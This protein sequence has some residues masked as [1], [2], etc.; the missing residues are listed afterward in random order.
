MKQKQEE[1]TLDGCDAI[2][3]PSAPD[4]RL[5]P[6]PLNEEWLASYQEAVL[7]AERPIIDAHHHLWAHRGRYLFDEILNDVRSGHNVKAT[8][9]VEADTMYRID[10]DPELACI[11]E[12]EFI[13][14]VAAMSA[15]GLCGDVRVCAGIVGFTNMLQ[16][17]GAG[18]IMDAHLARGGARFKGIRHCSAFDPDPALNTT[19]IVVPPGLLGATEFLNGFRHLSRRQLS[20][21]AWV[22]FTQLHELV[23]LADAFPDTLIV[24]DH[25]GA[26]IGIGQYEAD[27]V[28]VFE[29]WKAS[30]HTLALRENVFVKLGGFGM[31][32]F[33]FGLDQATRPASSA[34]LAGKWAPYVET[35][36]EAFGARRAMFE[37][38]FPVDK[39]TCSYRTLWN[40]FKRIVAGA[41]E[42]EKHDL[43]FDT[44]NR[45][46]RLELSPSAPMRRST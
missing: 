30:I 4:D 12:T 23:E 11:G 45:A 32:L 22:Y 26:P 25:V 17:D 28:A 1:N 39:V 27:P 7:D 6:V 15:S 42:S 18:R 21:D 35:C 3:H 31:P 5:G 19:P 24:L 33:G 34:E 36:I 29:R 14:G 10:G 38:N 46:Y 16:G 43:F 20:F 8:V 13:N 44:A 40:A 37:S 41:S 2:D 9:H